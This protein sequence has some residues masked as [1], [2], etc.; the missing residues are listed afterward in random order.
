MLSARFVIFG[1]L[2]AFAVAKQAFPGEEEKCTDQL[3]ECLEKVE[4]TAASC[5]EEGR[6]K[7]ASSASPQ[8]EEEFGGWS[9]HLSKI[10][11][12]LY[13]RATEAVHYEEIRAALR[14]YAAFAL[15]KLQ[16]VCEFSLTH[17]KA[18]FA[19]LQKKS[20]EVMEEHV[21]PQVDVAKTELSALYN[22]H[23]QERAA[24]ALD[25]AEPYLARFRA[26][27]VEHRGWE[28]LQV[29]REVLEKAYQTSIVLLGPVVVGALNSAYSVYQKGSLQTLMLQPITL[30][31]FGEEFYFQQG[32]WDVLVL[33]ALILFL[34][35]VFVTVVLK[36]FVYEFLF[37][38]VVLQVLI[39]GLVRNVLLWTLGLSWKML[40]A[41]VGVLLA[42]LKFACCLGCC[43]YCYRRKTQKNTRSSADFKDSNP[44]RSEVNMS[45][46]QGKASPQKPKLNG[47]KKK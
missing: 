26:L 11:E 45:P 28:A 14:Q 37:K 22:D 43:G 33:L 16:K 30:T 36:T 34:A 2:C 13:A 20:L 47:G 44:Q 38:F 4:K 25:Q 17:G 15:E 12:L 18:G 23:L 10:A 5:T 31:M 40:C 46:A 7:N 42:L 6:S 39:N 21:A 24:Q 32:L 41:V 27:E 29:A 3:Q 35:Y 8:E 19:V 9:R 1:A